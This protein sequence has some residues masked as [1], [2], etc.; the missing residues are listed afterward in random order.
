MKGQPT[1]SRGPQTRMHP[2]DPF[3]MRWHQWTSLIAASV[4]LVSLSV[5]GSGCV[6]AHAK[7]VAETPLEVPA[8]PPRIVEATDPDMPQPVPLPGEPARNPPSRVR[9]PA[10]PRVE[11]PR[12]A[13]EPPKAE[14]PPVEAA[15]PAEEQPKPA[16]PPATLQTT[17]TQREVEVERRVRAMLTQAS[18][19]LSHI[20]YQALNADAKT[21]Y[22][23]AKGFVRQAEDALRA[24][25]LNFASNLAD[26]AATLAAQL[27][28]R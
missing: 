17:P 25:N 4:L 2:S 7:S 11:A 6:R 23:T 12:P 1:R 28:G 20:N 26:K 21:Q 24:K 3:T 5:G 14:P 27:S 18:N 8:P 9:Q 16:P 22:D 19:D 13:P 15:K 10:P